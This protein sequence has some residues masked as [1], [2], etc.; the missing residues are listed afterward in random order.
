M[1]SNEKN[2]MR[3]QACDCSSAQSPQLRESE[4][5]FWILNAEPDIR[6][7]AAASWSPDRAYHV[8][9]YSDEQKISKGKGL[10]GDRWVNMT[11]YVPLLTVPPP[12]A[13]LLLVRHPFLRIHVQFQVHA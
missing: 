4:P 3:V 13:P 5:T 12:A 8:H 11:P 9:T 7:A 10:R 1:I 2:K 6:A